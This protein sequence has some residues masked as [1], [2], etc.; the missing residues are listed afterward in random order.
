MLQAATESWQRRDFQQSIEILERA[1]RLDPGNSNILLDLG[2]LYGRRY[3]YAAAERCF[4]RAIRIAPRK[5]EAL[6]TAGQKSRDFGNHAMAERYF[7]RTL[8][9]KDVSPETLVELAEIYERLRRL[10][11]ATALIDRALQARQRLRAGAAGARPAGSPGGPAGDRG[12]TDSLLSD[13]GR[14]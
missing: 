13:N 9:Q 1:S 5:T 8:E 12:K 3:D 14:P 10:D 6:V 2:G 4:E 7:Q 11:D